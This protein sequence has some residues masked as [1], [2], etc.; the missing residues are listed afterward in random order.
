MAV[1]FVVDIKVHDPQVYE[2]YRKLVNPTLE[3]YGGKFLVRGG[4]C[5]T[6]E[7]DW[8]PQRLVILEFDDTEQFKRWYYSPEYSEARS[9]RFQASTAQAILVQGV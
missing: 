6:I 8:Q 9:I 5:E 2:D 1:Y 7:G 3:R 4:T